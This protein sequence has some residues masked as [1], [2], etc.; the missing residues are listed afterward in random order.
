LTTLSLLKPEEQEAVDLVVGYDA[1]YSNDLSNISPDDIKRLE[2]LDEEDLKV[3]Y[4]LSST[5]SKDLDGTLTSVRLEQQK[6]YTETDRLTL[7]IERAREKERTAVEVLEKEAAF[8]EA[9]LFRLPVDT[10]LSE[11]SYGSYHMNQKDIPRDSEEVQNGAPTGRFFTRWGKRDNTYERTEGEFD[12]YETPRGH[13]LALVTRLEKMKAFLTSKIA[14]EPCNG[15]GAISRVL[16]EYGWEVVMSD[17]TTM[18]V[19][20]DF[21]TEWSP[22]KGEGIIITNTPYSN[23]A[24]FLR[25]LIDTGLPFAAL[26]PVDSIGYLSFAQE[27]KSL[28]CVRMLIINRSNRFI[29]KGKSVSLGTVA[30]FFGN[31]P[32]GYFENDVMFADE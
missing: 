29:N 8:R 2:T 9:I 4:S 30:W 22:T 31:F 23:K 25:K 7:R 24:A 27:L 32:E 1:L 13:T 26:Y 20:T 18:E 14:Y 5:R 21:L 3:L 11:L 16:M 6:V 15:H 10:N 12:L 17:I 19:S 28:D